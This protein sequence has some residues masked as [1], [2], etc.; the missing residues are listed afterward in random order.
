MYEDNGFMIN[1][2]LQTYAVEHYNNAYDASGWN[3]KNISTITD[4]AKNSWYR[5][6]G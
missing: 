5:A 6:P 2:K 3:Y 1:E 4:T